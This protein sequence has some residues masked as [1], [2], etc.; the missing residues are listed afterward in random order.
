MACFQD[1]DSGDND[2]LDELER[3]LR[4]KAL[5]SMQQAKAVLD[6]SGN[7]HVNDSDASSD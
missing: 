4:E 5:R 6:N 1:S 3:E 7:T 2:N